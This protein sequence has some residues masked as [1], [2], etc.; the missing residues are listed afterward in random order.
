MGKTMEK[1]ST[2]RDEKGN[3]ELRPKERGNSPK[4]KGGTQGTLISQSKRD[5]GGWRGAVLVVMPGLRGWAKG[6][7]APGPPFCKIL[8][9]ES[10]HQSNPSK[11]NRVQKPGLDFN[12]GKT[13]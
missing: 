12:L 9:F 1:G 8:Q 5:S 7:E 3:T 2:Q 13:Y 11:S 10:V 6:A 4:R